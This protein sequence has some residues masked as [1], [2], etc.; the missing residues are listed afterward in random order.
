[1]KIQ[2]SEINELVK[3]HP[4]ECVCGSDEA[5]LEK[6][7]AA[8]DS[9]LRGTARIILLAGPSSSGK[10]T[11]AGM[12]RKYLQENGR[13][14]L[15]ISMDD[16]YKDKSDP[17]YPRDE[18]G[19]L[20]FEATEALRID[21]IK[22]CLQKVLA[23]EDFFVPK[24]IFGEGRSVRDAERITLHQ[25]SFLIMEGLH[26]LNPIF[27][28]GL[29]K[30]SVTKIYISVSSDIYDG[31]K[32]MLSGRMI[33]FIRRMTRDSIYRAT[34]VFST[35]QRWGSVTQGEDRNL[36]P[37]KDT[38]DIKLNTFHLYELGLLKPLA[39]NAINA[40]SKELFGEYIKEII[41]ALEKV[42]PLDRALLSENSLLKE[43]VP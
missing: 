30:E 27:T 33:R 24:Y 34:D 6:I 3:H 1:M 18:E 41:S 8:A 20:D 10:T 23:G 17:S 40:S 26:A 25:N 28:E 12:L 13:D 19:R 21:E 15:I 35:L 4:Q 11:T 2:L 37:Y 14:A 29:A 9:I 16:F 32:L 22:R 5:Y 43:F 38:A 31:D 7:K 39:K 36:Y 42:E